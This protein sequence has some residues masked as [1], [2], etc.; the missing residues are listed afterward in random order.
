MLRPIQLAPVL[1][2]IAAVLA[3]AETSLSAEMRLPLEVR[4]TAGIRRRNDVVTARLP[5]GAEVGRKSRFRLLRE[6]EV[7]SAQFRQVER[8]DGATDLVV[9][10]VD[11]FAPYEA[12][13]YVLESVDADQEESVQPAGGLTLTESTEAYS[14]SSG[15]V[16]RW[17]IRKDLAGL[18]D[19]A[20]RDV[21]Y[22]GDSAGLWFASAAGGRQL[23]AERPPSRTVVERQGPIAC[24]LRFEFDD[25]PRGANSALVLEFVRTKSWV[26]AVWSIDGMPQDVDSFGAELELRLDGSEALVDFGAGDFVYATVTDEQAA[27]LAAGPR[28]KDHVPWQVLHG[29]RDRMHP[30]V[31]ASNQVPTSEVHGWAHVMDSRRCTALAIGDFGEEGED[32]ITVD[33]KGTLSW[34]RQI[35]TGQTTVRPT[36]DLE[37]WLHFVTMPVHIGART[38]PRSMQEPLEVRW[39]SE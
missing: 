34:T 8:P 6:D 10:F 32:S 37:F 38:S 9:D 25:W 28:Q 1:A 20:W 21:D 26:H 27:Q 12:R 24:S 7:I 13:E 5:A 18:L 29:P 2:A 17:T 23:L 19:V 16:V 22:I 3:A 31:V 15:G 39:L 30:I 35:K 11:H 4:E 33:G 36:R 14:V